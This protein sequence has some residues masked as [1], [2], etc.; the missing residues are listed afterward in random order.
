M[1]IIE[2]QA[3]I[4][5]DSMILTTK[6]LNAEVEEIEDIGKTADLLEILFDPADILYVL[7]TFDNEVR[8]ADFN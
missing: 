6:V 4:D 2:D 3:K 7:C 8:S 1:R 5:E